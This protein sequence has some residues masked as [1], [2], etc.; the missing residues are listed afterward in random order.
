MRI[1]LLEI[2]CPR[3]AKPG[4]AKLLFCK[5]NAESILQL[6]GPQTITVKKWTQTVSQDGSMR[7]DETEK[8]EFKGYHV[9]GIKDAFGVNEQNVYVELADGRYLMEQ[10]SVRKRYN[11]VEE[12]GLDGDDY[13]RNQDTFYE[14]SIDDEAPHE[15]QEA[16]DDLLD[17]LDD[18]PSL[19]LPVD[20]DS[21]RNLVFDCSLA[22]A[23]DQLLASIGC[24]LVYDPLAEDEEDRYTITELDTNFSTEILDAVKKEGRLIAKSNSTASTQ[25]RVP[26]KIRVFPNDP[27]DFTSGTLLSFPDAVEFDIA[28]ATGDLVV[29]IRDHEIGVVEDRVE[30]VVKAWYG[31]LSKPRD[32]IYQGI[33]KQL[34]DS[35][36][37]RVCWY[38]EDGRTSTQIQNLLPG[39]IPWP[40]PY[41]NVK[42]PPVRYWGKIADDIGPGSGGTLTIWNVLTNEETEETLGVR[43][44]APTAVTADDGF[45]GVSKDGLTG[46]WII[47]TKFCPPEE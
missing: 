37:T 15:Y 6:Q 34:N 2:D 43:N 33:V 5:E 12:K 27:F 28:G 4:K 18:P 1:P 17:M 30:S 25:Y 31:P 7:W 32:E 39:E 13:D 36:I 35:E 16:L 8:Y 26:S 42:P 21:P 46:A 45:I 40:K 19:F 44:I 23:I 47:D 29:T 10:T 9:L 38:F 20:Y 11:L 3:G 22:D 24:A 14:D 41:L